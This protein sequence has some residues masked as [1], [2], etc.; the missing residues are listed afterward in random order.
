MTVPADREQNKGGSE[1]GSS[2]ALRGRR[3]SRKERGKGG[4]VCEQGG[5]EEE[6]VAEPG[7]ETGVRQRNGLFWR[8]ENSS[9]LGKISRRPF[10]LR[11]RLRMEEG[12]ERQERKKGRVLFADM[13]EQ[14]RVVEI[15]SLRVGSRPR[16]REREKRKREMP[17]SAQKLRWGE[18]WGGGSLNLRTCIQ[19]V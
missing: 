6:T 5:G 2:L 11:G 8:R 13:C 12:G 4:G 9:S 16:M 15:T 3:R 14:R 10:T 18:V 7:G 1:R 19:Q 17:K